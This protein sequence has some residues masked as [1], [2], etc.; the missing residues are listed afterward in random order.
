MPPTPLVGLSIPSWD[1]QL[2]PSR[3]SSY[4]PL[5]QVGLGRVGLLLALAADSASWLLGPPQTGRGG[6]TA[7]G[8]GRAALVTPQAQAA[9]GPASATGMGTHAE[10]TATTS[11]G[12][13]SARTTLRAPTASSALLATMGTPGEPGATQAGQGGVRDMVV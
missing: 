5:S 4:P 3:G 12:S 2:L 11:A 6:N 10:A 1:L 13:A 7:N 9:A 8:A